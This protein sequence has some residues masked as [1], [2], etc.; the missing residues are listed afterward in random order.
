MISETD[1]QDLAERIAAK[2]KTEAECDA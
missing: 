1:K 2:R